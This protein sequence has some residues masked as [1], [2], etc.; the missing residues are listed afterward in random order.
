MPT[1]ENEE[2]ISKAQTLCKSVHIP[3]ILSSTEFWFQD[4]QIQNMSET[5]FGNQD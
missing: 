1:M 5:M 4:S 2:I 3:F